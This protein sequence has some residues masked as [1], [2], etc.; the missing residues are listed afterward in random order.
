LGRVLVTAG[1][2][3]TFDTM[4]VQGVRVPGTVL[5][6]NPAVR[7]P[8]ASVAFANGAGQRWLTTSA[9]GGYLAFLPAGTDDLQAFNAAAASFRSITLLGRQTGDIRMVTASETVRRSVDRDVNG[10]GAFAPGEAIASVR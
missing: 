10:S 1:A 3:S 4:F 5:D 2:T 6:A 9:T 7:N 8:Q